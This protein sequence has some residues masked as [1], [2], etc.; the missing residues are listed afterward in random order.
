VDENR[1]T[2]RL[3]ALAKEYLGL[4]K[5][6]KVL[7]KAAAE[8]G[9]DPKA[10]MW[11]LPARFVGGYAEQDAVITLKLW[12]H[13]TTELDK[14]D[15]WS[16]F[17]L[18]SR[19]LPAV[20]DMRS[21]GV[22]VDL[23]RAEQ[24][25]KVL[26]SRAKELKALIKDKTGVAVEPW[27][28]ESVRKVFD[29]LNLPFA[30]TETGQPS[31]TKD[32]LKD[33]PHEVVRSINSLRETDKAD[34]TFIDSILKFEHNSRIHC[35]MHQLRGDDGGTVTGRF[36]VAADTLIETQRGPVPI[37]DIRPRK[38]FALTHRGRMQ[39]IRHLI[40]KGEEKMV[41]VRVSS[42]RVLKCTQ[43]H[44]VLT[45]SGWVRVGQLVVGQEI[46]SVDIQEGLGQRG[47]LL[48]GS[49]PVS[50]RGQTHDQRSGQG[51]ASH[52]SYG[53]RD[54]A[55][56]AVTRAVSGGESAS[57]VSC[58]GRGQ[59]PDDGK[60]RGE[61]PQLQGAIVLRPTWVRSDTQAGVVYGQGGLETYLRAQC[62]NGQDAWA[63]RSARGYGGA[64]HRR[65]SNK[66][67]PGQLGVGH[68]FGAPDLTCTV[69]V[70]EI[71]PLGVAQVWDIEVETDHSYVAH[72]LIHHNSSSHPNLQQIPARDPEVKKMIRG[73]F[74]PEEGER[75][76]SFDYASQEP[77][78][79]THFAASMP[80]RLRD[81]AVDAVVKDFH[82]GG[83]DLHQMVADMAGISRKEAKTINLGIM[84]G[85]GAAKLADQL[86]ITKEKAKELMSLHQEK[87]P[88][89]KSLAEAASRQAERQGKIRTVLGRLCRFDMWE[90]R[91]FGYNKP[92]KYEE[93]VRE[94]GTVGQGIRRAFT[95]KALNRL[96]Q[97]SAADQTKLAFAQCYEAGIQ[98][99]LQVHDELCFSVASDDQAK[100]IVEIMENG[101]DLRV[102]SKVDVALVKDWGE[103]D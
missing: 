11:K 56:A 94:Y 89:V 44:R 24:S 55:S 49:E 12:N 21:Q 4:R 9:I 35:E 71:K 86:S 23:D 67:Q 27:A 61:T 73:I 6:E 82:E 20:I 99:M 25:R 92:L 85:M 3:D 64:S 47:A 77:R 37:V 39:P 1:L 87:V 93:A 90:P 80:G 76:G 8:W 2:Y 13:L 101:L 72:G 31:F 95:Y 103:V 78:L 98:P 57:V 33:H 40:Y 83:A 52:I 70:E 45:A 54:G 41:A 7:R 18:E 91:S 84:Y 36:C 75:W 15:L 28:A 65:E 58:Q 97:G 102:P 29:A 10:E 42:G 100:Q 59:K 66:Q 74:V 88:F 69:T 96:I 79:L 32:F 43:N 16:I 53:A 14:Q 30:T 19:V 81:G 22:R 62:G 60:V 63:D 68:P 34:S 51:D 17:D 5:D 48:S 50:V 26:R 38:D 46:N